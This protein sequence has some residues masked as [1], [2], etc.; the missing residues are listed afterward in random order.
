MKNYIRVLA[1]VFAF[2]LCVGL[3]AA[4]EVTP[5]FNSNENRFAEDKNGGNANP[6]IRESVP[7][8]IPADMVGVVVDAN[9][10]LITWSPYVT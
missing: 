9:E 5:S 3:F 10:Q 6:V 2:A 8:V 1:V 4:C 7:Y